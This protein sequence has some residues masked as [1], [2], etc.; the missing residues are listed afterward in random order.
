MVIDCTAVAITA[1]V[2]AT[3]TAVGTIRCE[4]TVADVEVVAA[5][6]GDCATGAVPADA[7]VIPRCLVAGEG[8]FVE[9]HHC[10]RVAV[11][12]V[13]R[14]AK[15]ARAVVGEGGVVHADDAVVDIQ[16]ATVDASDVALEREIAK[17]GRAT[18][19]EDSRAV[20]VGG[21][22]VVA[23]TVDAK[24]RALV[25]QPTTAVGGFVEAEIH[26]VERGGGTK[27]VEDAATSHGLVRVEEHISQ[28]DGAQVIQTT[29]IARAASL[30][31]G[32]F[33]VGEGECNAGINKQDALVVSAADRHLV[34]VVAAINRRVLQND[35]LEGHRDRRGAT[36]VKC[37]LT[38]NGQGC[39]QPGLGAVGYNRRSGER[40]KWKSDQEVAQHQQTGQNREQRAQRGAASD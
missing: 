26:L 21:V 3:I 36:T 34:A 10:Q 1:I 9:L 19:E 14:P 29:T 30:A 18:I 15:I 4:G 31:I 38:T 5:G 12:V 20:I 32:N 23:T 22:V 8:D 37:D 7:G 27:S 17:R 16:A 2:R 25:E 35:L 13:D 24:Q 28:H 33:D 11:A 6:H 39:V 40:F